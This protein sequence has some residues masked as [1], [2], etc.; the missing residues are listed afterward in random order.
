MDGE[1]VAME[2]LMSYNGAVYTTP[3][4]HIWLLGKRGCL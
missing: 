3:F 1:V 4:R 2:S